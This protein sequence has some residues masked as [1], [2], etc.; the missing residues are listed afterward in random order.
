MTLF[1]DSNA[2]ERPDVIARVL[3][4]E[5]ARVLEHRADKGGVY[6]RVCRR[7]ATERH[8]RFNSEMA[9]FICKLVRRWLEEQ[10]WYRNVEIIGSAA[11]NST[12]AAFAVQTGHL[13]R[14]GAGIETDSPKAGAY[15]PTEMGVQF[16]LGQP[17]QTYSHFWTYDGRVTR[18]DG[19]IIN[20]QQALR[21]K[22]DWRKLMGNE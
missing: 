8:R 7:Q 14:T 12:D 21:E 13:R 10:R 15:Q 17:T 18:V 19:D 16:A 6:C 22:F 5:A 11:K 3:E 2:H 4:A 20:V 9:V 1:D